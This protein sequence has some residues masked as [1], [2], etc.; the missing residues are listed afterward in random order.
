MNIYLHLPKYLRQ[1]VLHDFGDAEGVVRFPRGSAEHD[2][3]SHTLTTQPKN[4]KPQ[5]PDEE[6]VAIEL[7]ELKYKP[8][9]FYCYLTERAR[10]MLAQ[11]IL[12][13]F[14]IMLW[15]DLHDLDKLQCS[16]TD[17]IY[18]WMERHGIDDDPTSWETI[19]QTYFRQRKKY[20]QENRS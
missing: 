10:K 8:L 2:V 14:R 9:P 7:P 17:V 20:C 19:R 15:H 11:V 16:I 13:R 18:D 1:W 4:A 12:I 6:S 5:L 3:L